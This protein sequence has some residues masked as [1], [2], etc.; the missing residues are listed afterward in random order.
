MYL[1]AGLPAPLRSLGF[2]TSGEATGSDPPRIP[3]S[4]ELHGGLDGVARGWLRPGVFTVL[5]MVK[6]RG[7]ADEGR[8]RWWVVGAST[9]LVWQPTRGLEIAAGPSAG[10]LSFALVVDENLRLDTASAGGGLGLG[11]AGTGRR[12]WQGRMQLRSMWFGPPLVRGAWFNQPLGS[13]HLVTATV[14]VA[15]SPGRAHR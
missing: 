13:T 15:W 3:F 5:N 1:G 7:R 11:V 4:I 8:V 12:G 14:G 9:D 2:D 6:G 10:M